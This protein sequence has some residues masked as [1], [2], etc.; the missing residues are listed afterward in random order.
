M[1]LVLAGLNDVRFNSAFLPYLLAQLRLIFMTSGLEKREVYDFNFQS[2][3]SG[4]FAKFPYF[5]KN[6]RV[7][8]KS[9]H[10]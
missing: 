10:T 4:L 5:I 1:V 7:I 3:S 6:Y 8:L 2:K 9:T